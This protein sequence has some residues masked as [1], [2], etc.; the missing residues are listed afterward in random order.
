MRQLAEDLDLAV[1][2][3]D[4]LGIGEQLAA[5]HFQGNGSP[6]V[7]VPGLEDLAGAAL[8]EAFDQDIRTQ[9]QTLTVVEKKLIDLV[10]GQPAALEQ[11]AGQ[12]PRLR[13]SGAATGCRLRPAASG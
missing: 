5:N 6:Q 8:A 3:A 12:R 13:A 11:V 9:Q 10:R 1:E 4:H 2:T 7:L